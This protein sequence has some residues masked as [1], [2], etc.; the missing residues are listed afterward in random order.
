[1]GSFETKIS[2]QVHLFLA[3][4]LLGLVKLNTSPSPALFRACCAWFAGHMTRACSL[5]VLVLKKRLY[6]GCLSH[7]GRGRGTTDTIPNLASIRET[8]SC[9]ASPI[10]KKMNCIFFFEGMNCICILLTTIYTEINQLVI[11]F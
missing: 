5:L 1:M 8:D 11:T 7:K 9:L 2:N 6:F 3:N 10:E 4:A